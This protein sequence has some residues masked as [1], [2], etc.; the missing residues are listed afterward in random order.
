MSALGPTSAP[1]ANCGVLGFLEASG[2]YKIDYTGRNALN[3]N[4]GR[5]F[6]THLTHYVSWIAGPS[7]IR[8][9]TISNFRFVHKP[10]LR[11]P[12]LAKVCP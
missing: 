8:V 2:S 5:T 3:H 11:K 9:T 4:H 10:G 7:R 6:E 12:K 1:V